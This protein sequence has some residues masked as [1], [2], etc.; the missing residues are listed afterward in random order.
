MSTVLHA[1]NVMIVDDHS[2]VR[3][4]LAAIIAREPGIFICAECEDADQAVRAAQEKAPDLAIVDLIARQGIG[5]ALVPP[6][7]AVP[8]RSADSRPLHA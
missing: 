7:V 1:V 4:G 3:A 8:A 6:I 2:I 5:A